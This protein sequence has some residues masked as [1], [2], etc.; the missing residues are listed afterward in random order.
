MEVILTS[1]N[2]IKLV[3]LM[4]D[5]QFHDGTSMG[6]QLDITRAANKSWLVF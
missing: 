2:L 5:K 3:D 1:Q 6:V 4:N